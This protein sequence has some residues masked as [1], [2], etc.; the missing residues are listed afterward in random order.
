MHTVES[1]LFADLTYVY[2]LLHEFKWTNVVCKNFPTQ[3][4]PERTLGGI[5]SWQNG[6][7]G[8]NFSIL[9]WIFAF[10]VWNVWHIAVD[11]HSKTFACCSRELSTSLLCS[12]WVAKKKHFQ[13][14][15]FFKALFSGSWHGKWIWKKKEKFS[16]RTLTLRWL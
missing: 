8:W 12:R 1:T 16:F 2:L 13:Q 3:R 15:K 11:I 7:Q 9:N 6:K 4:P 14:I 10:S 5:I